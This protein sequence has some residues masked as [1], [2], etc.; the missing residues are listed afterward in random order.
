MIGTFNLVCMSL[1]GRKPQAIK[2]K[3]ILVYL[4][5]EFCIVTTIT[6]A[7]FTASIAKTRTY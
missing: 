1:H 2:K 3:E 5:S 7:E 6:L 4:I